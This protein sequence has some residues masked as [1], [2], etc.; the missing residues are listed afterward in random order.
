MKRILLLASCIVMTA[1]QPM[2]NQKEGEVVILNCELSGMWSSRDF[3]QPSIGQPPTAT[4]TQTT[5]RITS[6]TM[7]FEVWSDEKNAFLPLCDKGDICKASKSETQFRLS[8]ASYLQDKKAG[9]E[10]DNKSE[11]TISRMSGAITLNRQHTHKSKFSH[12]I[13]TINS[14][15]TCKPAESPAPK[16]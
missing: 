12:L 13:M 2:A 3:I 11:W 16:F 8:T 7:P 5:L 10:S 14:S 6:A 4:E 1:C 15:G 9:W